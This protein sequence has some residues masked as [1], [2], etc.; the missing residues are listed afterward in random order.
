MLE[1]TL[2][3]PTGR[4]N[5]KNTSQLD[6]KVEFSNR[7]EIFVIRHTSYLWQPWFFASFLPLYHLKTSSNLLIFIFGGHPHFLLLIL[8][9]WS[10]SFLVIFILGV[11]SFLGWTDR[12]ELC[13]YRCHSES[14]IE[15]LAKFYSKASFCMVKID[16]FRAPQHSAWF[17]FSQ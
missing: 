6:L 3:T 5:K 4:P 17:Y 1:F 16:H 15:L 13:I 9:V 12:I 10:S 14:T 2:K 11:S 8:F 7:K